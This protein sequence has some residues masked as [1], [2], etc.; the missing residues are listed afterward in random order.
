MSGFQIEGKTDAWI[1]QVRRVNFLFSVDRESW[2]VKAASEVD[3]ENFEKSGDF[4]TWFITCSEKLSG[5]RTLDICLIEDH[6]KRI[7]YD[8][9]KK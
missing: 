3:F 1:S 8:N 9:D 4:I 6:E 5:S 7:Y 2:E